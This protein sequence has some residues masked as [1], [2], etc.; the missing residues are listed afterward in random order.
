MDEW[1]R[2]INKVRTKPVSLFHDILAIGI[3]SSPWEYIL[4]IKL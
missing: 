1:M 2:V 4:K 3:D